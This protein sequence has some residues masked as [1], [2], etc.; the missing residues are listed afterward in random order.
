MPLEDRILVENTKTEDAIFPHKTA[1]SE[2]NVKTNK[3]ENTK[4]S[5]HNTNNG[6]CH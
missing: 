5:Y 1:I 4:R 6:V 3:M 2:G